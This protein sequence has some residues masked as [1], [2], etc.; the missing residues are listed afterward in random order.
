ML[1][2]MISLFNNFA[3][4]LKSVLP[5]SPFVPFID[6]FSNLPYISWLNWFIPVGEIINVLTA[7]LGAI[8][9]FYAYSIVLRWV[10]AI[11]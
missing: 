2:W 3:D 7:W 6:Q 1:D 8:L 9:L 11:S 5:M 4:T 10:K